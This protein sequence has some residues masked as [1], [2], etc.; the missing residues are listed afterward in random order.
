MF[1]KDAIEALA[2]GAAISQ[3]EEAVTHAL[4]AEGA[5]ALPEH[6]KMHDLEGYMP[7]RR[8]ARGTMSTSAVADFASYVKTNLEAGAAV[9]VDADAMSATAVLNLGTP[10]APGHADN[11]AVVKAKITA[12]YEALKAHANGR[13][14]GQASVAEFFEDWAGYLL[15]FKDSESVSPPKAIAAIRKITIESMRKLESEEKSL[16]ASRST[17]ENV[18]ATSADPIPTTIYF[19][20]TPYHG[21]MERNFVLRLSVITSNDKPS[22]SLR[23]VKQE[24]HDEAMAQ[25][26]ARLVDTSLRGEVPVML[27]SY[28][29]R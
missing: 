15:F 17:F 4:Q 9:F 26:F 11:K 2:E 12:A 19:N 18:Q 28:A 13:G 23:I 29:T 21:L 24:E 7:T 1:D 22:I 14:I 10:T 25:E 20:C 16:S 6:F 8:R 5:A 3:A 27:G